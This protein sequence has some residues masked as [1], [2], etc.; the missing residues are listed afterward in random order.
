MRTSTASATPA[1]SIWSHVIIHLDPAFP[2]ILNAEFQ[3]D[4]SIKKLS[5]GR[6]ARD[7]VILFLHHFVNVQLKHLRPGIAMFVASIF[8]DYSDGLSPGP[9]TFT[10][11][12]FL[13]FVCAKLWQKLSIRKSDLRDLLAAFGHT[14]LLFPYAYSQVGSALQIK[15]AEITDAEL[16]RLILL[17][18]AED[19]E[20]DEEL[21]ALL[22]PYCQLEEVNF[23][24]DHC[25]D[26]KLIDKHLFYL[27]NPV[28]SDSSSFATISPAVVDTPLRKYKG[29]T[30]VPW[31]RAFSEF[32]PI[33]FSPLLVAF[34]VRLQH[35][36]LHC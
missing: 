20:S 24:I 35:Q 19:D 2:S 3:L 4:D 18:E 7:S 17:L 30:L 9:A 15:T 11:G 34:S 33:E 6:S 12:H 5:N 25:Q 13:Q 26:A 21:I 31:T 22:A 36:L 16:N 28:K 32:D 23:T 14:A 27:R 29:L 1:I 10:L 8:K